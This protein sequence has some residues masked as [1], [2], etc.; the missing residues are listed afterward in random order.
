M[1]IFDQPCLAIAIEYR[2]DSA[3]A[4]GT[5]ESEEMLPGLRDGRGVANAI[6]KLDSVYTINI[7]RLAKDGVVEAEFGSGKT[8]HV[9]SEPSAAL[10]S[11][12]QPV[13]S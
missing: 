3:E 2:L 6:C 7:P 1:G 8:L 13:F 10:L 4:L 11:S 9:V 12:E 5:R